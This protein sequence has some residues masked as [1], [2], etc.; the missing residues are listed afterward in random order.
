MADAKQD[1]YGWLIERARDGAT[2]E[3]A[4]ELRWLSD[5]DL[6]VTWTTDS[7]NAIRF[8]RREDA[9]KVYVIIGETDKVSVTDHV[10]S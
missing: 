5:D 1:E 8:C 7:Y 9:E 10:W 3:W 2:P 6:H 4:E